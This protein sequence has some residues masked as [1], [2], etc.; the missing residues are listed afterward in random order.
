MGDREAPLSHPSPDFS[1]P[2]T[3]ALV[4]VTSERKATTQARRELLISE[5]QLFLSLE[6]ESNGCFSLR[7]S[8]SRRQ[9]AHILVLCPCYASFSSC[10]V[11]PWWGLPLGWLS[12]LYGQILCHILK[13]KKR[14]TTKDLGWG[15]ALCKTNYEK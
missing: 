11:R 10:C 2:G 9:R 5:A 15:E 1:L 6:N 14:L 13:K 12:Y 4:L 8:Q 3:Q 7:Q